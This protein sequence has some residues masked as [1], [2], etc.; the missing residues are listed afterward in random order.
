VAKKTSGNWQQVVVVTALMP[1]A[2]KG[3]EE[4][5]KLI[6]EKIKS[7]KSG[8]SPARKKAS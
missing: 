3:L 4:L 1:V 8:K 7:K 5:T 2:Q 6:F